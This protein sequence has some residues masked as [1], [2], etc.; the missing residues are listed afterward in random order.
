MTNNTNLVNISIKVHPDF[1]EK[2]SKAA[3]KED[4]LGIG[5]VSDYIR[6]AIQA[7]VDGDPERSIDLLFLYNLLSNKFR[8]K[9]NLTDIE[10]QHLRKIEG[11]I[12]E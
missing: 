2:I 1:K 5:N 4:S 8:L 9:E 12:S 11:D 3:Q 10:K 6:R 7:K